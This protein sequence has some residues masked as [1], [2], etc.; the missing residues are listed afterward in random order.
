MESQ[1]A[2]RL[3]M[4]LKTLKDYG[5]ECMRS[6]VIMKKCCLVLVVHLMQMVTVQSR[7]LVSF[8]VTHTVSS[9]WSKQISIN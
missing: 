4:K 2:L 3:Q 5:A 8:K 6:K 9:S 1:R 7:A